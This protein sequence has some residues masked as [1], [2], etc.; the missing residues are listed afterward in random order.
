MSQRD[1]LLDEREIATPDQAGATGSARALEMG[2]HLI[3]VR[4][5]TL[6]ALDV[7]LGIA[8]ETLRVELRAAVGLDV[9]LESERV[10]GSFGAIGPS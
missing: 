7:E 4:D 2:R 3:A 8:R 1:L 10:G 9:S 6:H 5:T